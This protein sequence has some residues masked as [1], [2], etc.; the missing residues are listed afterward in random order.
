[1]KEM[2]HKDLEDLT[3][4]HV[5]KRVEATIEVICSNDLSNR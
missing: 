3:F 4:F 1:M 2:T 5:E